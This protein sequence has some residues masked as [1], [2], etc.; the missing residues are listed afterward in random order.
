MKRPIAES[1][2]L[3]SIFATAKGVAANRKMWS[4]PGYGLGLSLSEA[5]PVEHAQVFL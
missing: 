3:G 2:R 5:V 1:P 4:L